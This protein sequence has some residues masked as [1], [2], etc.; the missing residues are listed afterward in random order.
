[1]ELTREQKLTIKF[2]FKNRYS[3]LSLD[4]RM[5]K[6]R[7]ALDIFSRINGGNGTLLISCPTHLIYNWLAEIE[8]W[9]PNRWIVSIFDKGK[10]I[11]FPF[12]SDIVIT[13]LDLATREDYLFEWCSMLVVDEAHELK[14][15]TSK[16]TTF[17]HKHIY[18]NSIPRVHLLTASPLKNRVEEFYSLMAMCY[19]NPELEKSNFLTKYPDSISFA[20]EFSLKKKFLIEVNGRKVPVIKWYGLKREN[21]FRLKQY[22]RPIYVRFNAPIDR[23]EEIPY[24]ISNSPNK[25]LAA[26]F[27]EYYG[28]KD[29]Q[30]VAGGAKL[31]SAMRKIPFTIERVNQILEECGRCVIYTDHRPVCKELAEHYGVPAVTGEMSGKRRLEIA[32]EFQNG[33]REVFVATAGSFNSGA[34]LTRAKDLVWNDFPWVPITIYQ[35]NRRLDGPAQKEAKFNIHVVF[36]SPQDMKIYNT[37]KEKR[38]TIKEVT[39]M[40]N[41]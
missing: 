39:G 28:H 29:N 37:L 33:E 17:Y 14:S 5:G 11:Y 34:S 26:Q 9:F 3:I 22:L 36:G 38:E 21:L 20:E 16:R 4:A 15:M 13:S 23:I 27:G 6:T 1:M 7:T 35:V 24:L 8:M 12:H 40:K 31:D 25:E 30:S 41:V 10:K 2:A 32:N 19:Y 18:E